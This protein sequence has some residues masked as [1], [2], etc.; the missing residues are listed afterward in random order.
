MLGSSGFA[1]FG[2]MQGD[3]RAVCHDWWKR[4]SCIRGKD[5]N[6]IHHHQ[7][8]QSSICKYHLKG[9]CF[10]RDQ[11]CKY[12]HYLRWPEDDVRRYARKKKPSDDR[13]SRDSWSGGERRRSRSR[14]YRR[15]DKTTRNGWTEYVDKDGKPY[16]HNERTDETQWEKP[17]GWVMVWFGHENIEKPCFP[18]YR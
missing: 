17:D 1:A 10:Y 4:R 14:S 5:C 9:E 16:Y 11:C 13:R 6:F 2:R 18:R 3:T 8:L 12:K 15:D 7:S